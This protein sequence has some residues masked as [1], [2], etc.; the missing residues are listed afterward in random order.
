MFFLLKDGDFPTVTFV[1]RGVII[2][3]FLN[4][5]QFP[6]D[7]PVLFAFSFATFPFSIFAIALLAFSLALFVTY[8]SLEGNLPV[9]DKKSGFKASDC[10]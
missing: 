3:S 2:Q 1:F 7:P 4:S 9:K 10:Q 8:K 6:A 5:F